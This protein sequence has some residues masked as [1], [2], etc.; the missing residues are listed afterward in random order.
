MKALRVY[1]IFDN[2]CETCRHLRTS[3]RVDEVISLSPD[4]CKDVSIRKT[5]PVNHIVLLR[6]AGAMDL[7]P[8]LAGFTS[9]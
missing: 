7:D 5:G 9:V 3:F 1:R 8:M 2:I 6:R 4:G